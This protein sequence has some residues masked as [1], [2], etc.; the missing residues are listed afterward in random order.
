MK[1]VLFLISILVL[2]SLACQMSGVPSL[3]QPTPQPTIPV[4]AP[5]LPNAPD[6]A[7]SDNTLVAL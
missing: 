3:V 5:V 6:P 7:A 4:S 2:A 1:R